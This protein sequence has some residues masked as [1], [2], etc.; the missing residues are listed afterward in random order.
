MIDGRMRKFLGEISLVGQS[1]VKDPS[2][3]VG[4][5][6]KQHQVNVLEFLRFEAGEGIEKK[7]D[8]FAE[9]VMAQV[10]GHG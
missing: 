7:V 6:L 4:D 8:N 10:K 1:F 3:T 9:E 5:L 2:I